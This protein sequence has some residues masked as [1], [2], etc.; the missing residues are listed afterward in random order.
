VA[1]RRRPS[2][3]RSAQTGVA[4]EEWD[5]VEAEVGPKVV[6]ESVAARFHVDY[7]VGAFEGWTEPLSSVS[8]WEALADG[9]TIAHTLPVC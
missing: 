6:G 8:I 7:P 1:S 9:L 4:D 2:I 3:A 5:V